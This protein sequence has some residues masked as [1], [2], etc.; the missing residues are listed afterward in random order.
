MTATTTPEALVDRLRDVVPNEVTPVGEMWN[1]IEE[2]ADEIESLIAERDALRDEVERVR[3]AFQTLLNE[4]SDPV[5]SLGL[6]YEV[7]QITNG[8]VDDARAA[9][10]AK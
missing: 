8:T 1:L 6:D 5:G 2:A 4:M 10:E 7:R 3:G 9:P